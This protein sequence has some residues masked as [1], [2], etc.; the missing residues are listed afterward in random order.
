LHR[1]AEPDKAWSDRSSTHWPPQYWH[2][3]TGMA[4]MLILLTAV[5]TGLRALFFGVPPNTVD[6]LRQT[7][8]IPDALQPI[9]T[10]A[11]GYGKASDPPSPSLR[12]GHRPE[13]DVIHRG[14]W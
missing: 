2:S 12:R 5:D 10:V 11:G 13:H 9:G 8:G 6:T 14:R 7:F 4:A 1:Y 3:D